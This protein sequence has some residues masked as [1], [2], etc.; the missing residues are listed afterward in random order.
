[1][2]NALVLICIAAAALSFSSC[3]KTKKLA[4]QHSELE[5]TYQTLKRDMSEA[6]V[7]LEG[8]KVK[9][10]LPEA[11]LFNV[12]SA[13]MN[14]EYL[15]ILAKMATILNKYDK[16]SVLITGYTDVTGTESYN[17]DLSKKRAESAKS[18]LVK[19]QVNSGR[20][21]TWGLGDKNPVADNKTL[22]G[23]KQ[24]RRVEYVILYDYK[25]SKE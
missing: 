14:A 19:N 8:E 17:L 20:I 18:V 6:E 3:S 1:M 25:P 21:F 16:T 2:R 23:R 5:D 10:V 4:R 7:T 12:N 11:V 22:E 24:N 15:P 13:D 9:V